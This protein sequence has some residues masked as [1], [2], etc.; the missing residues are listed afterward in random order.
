MT[1]NPCRQIVTVYNGENK[2]VRKMAGGIWEPLTRRSG[3]IL[4]GSGYF[5]EY[6]IVGG[7]PYLNS[8]LIAGDL[9]PDSVAEYSKSEASYV[10]IIAE[11]KSTK[12]VLKRLTDG[13]VIYQ[14][15]LPEK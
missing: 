7:A 14:T 4:S 11:G 2:T 3:I 15:E 6:A 10:M 13:S 5:A 8:S 1:C 9:W 12:V